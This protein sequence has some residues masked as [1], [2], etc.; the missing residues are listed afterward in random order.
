LTGHACYNYSKL[1]QMVIRFPLKTRQLINHYFN[2]KIGPHQIVCPYFQNITRKRAAPVYAGKGLPEEIEKE[3]K[4]IF[5]QEFLAQVD[6]QQLR[7]Y[8]I[9]ADLGIDCSGLATNI[10]ASFLKEKGLKP[11]QQAF[12]Y[13][14]VNPFRQLIFQL[15]PR[16]NLSAFILTHPLNTTLVKDLNQVRPG[17]LLKISH[18]HVALVTEVEIDKQKEITSFRYLHS[19]SDYLDQQGVRQGKIILS[20]K[21]KPLEKQK[22]LERYRGKNWLREDFLKAKPSERGIYHLKIV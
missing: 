10:L 14:S 22:W 19:T 16:S 12:K 15:R 5:R 8:L 2:L 4:K 13:P 3:A 11:I 21:G 20:Q 7:L 17:D 18:H 1:I 9:Q 6:S